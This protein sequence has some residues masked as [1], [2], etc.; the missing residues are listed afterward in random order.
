MGFRFLQAFSRI[1]SPNSLQSDVYEHAMSPLLDRFVKGDNC[2]FFAY[3]M[4]NSGKT[5]T[6]QGSSADQ[7]LLPRLVSDI[8]RSIEDSRPIDDWRLSVS[9]LEIYQEKIF[10]LLGKKS[11]KPE[12]LT[13][14]DGNGKIEVCKLSEHSV[15]SIMDATRIM[16][17]AATN[18]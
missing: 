2:V 18:R 14:R 13:I 5:H 1:F 3:G 17:L 11:E 8:L 16:D 15:T 12:K 6:I 7:G 10:D 4:T 9:V